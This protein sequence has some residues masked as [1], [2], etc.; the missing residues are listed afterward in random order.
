MDISTIDDD[1]YGGETFT[2]RLEPRQEFRGVT[3][4]GCT[5]QGC[6][7]DEAVF[8]NCD[9]TECRFESTSLSLVKF[10]GTTFSDTVFEGCRAQSVGWTQ[11]IP[12]AVSRAPLTFEKCKLTYSSF[13]DAN[14]KRWTFADCDL[15][16]ADFSHAT[17]TRAIIRNCN[18]AKARFHG[19]D[20]RDVSLVSSY[21]YAFDPRDAKVSGLRVTAD[22]GASLLRAFGIEIVD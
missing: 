14:L 3:F 6:V 16:E 15:T 20:L 8:R 18:F 22:A 4:E 10:P 17:L 7:L 13:A 19:A 21:N 2:G 5:F 1:Y 12:N 11:V 9:F